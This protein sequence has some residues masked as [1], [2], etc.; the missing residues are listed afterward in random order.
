MAIVLFDSSFAMVLMLFSFLILSLS[1]FDMVRK[2]CNVIV[3]NQN[4]FNNV[5]T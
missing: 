5:G 1:D 4:I 2:E 3:H